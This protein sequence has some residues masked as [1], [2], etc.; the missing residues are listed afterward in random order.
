VRRWRRRGLAALAAG[1][2]LLS[3]ALLLDRLFP[4]PLAKLAELSVS[5]LD[6]RGEVLRAFP[7]GDG[8]WR[9]PTEPGEI[10]PRYR[11]MLLAWE[12]RRFAG[13]PGVDPLAVLRALWQDAAAGRVVS[14]A[15]TLTMQTARLL[16]PRPRRLGAKL[17][18]MARALQ[19]ERRL[20]K[21]GV[22]AAY[23]TLAPFGGNI[24]GVRAAARAYLGKEP[25]RLTDAEAALLVALPQAPE[26][27]RPDRFPE[28]ARQARDRVL[29]RMAELGVLSPAAVREAMQAPVP[30]RRLPA[31]M[32][33]PHL[34][35]RLRAAGPGRV[36]LRSLID[37]G[38]QRRLEAIAAAVQAGLEPGATVALLVVE[39]AGRAVRAY[40]GSAAYLDADSY[41][42]NDMVRAVR[43]PGS[44]LKPFIYGLGFDKLVVHPDTI[45]LDAPT[46]FGDYRPQNFDH[47]YRG[48]VTAREALQLSLNVPAVA[49]LDR[50]G[51]GLLMQA[52]REAGVTLRLPPGDDAPGLPIALGGAGLSLESL[53]RLYAALA[54]GGRSA[55]L[56]LTPDAPDGPAAR[57]V[58]PVAAWYLARILEQAPPPPNAI[59]PQ[60][61]GRAHPIA[62]KTGTSYGFRDAWAV[63]YDSRY[64]VGVWVGRPDG[65]FAADRLGRVTAAPLLFQVFAELPG[66]D[67]SAA[68]TAA[69]AS[70]P[71]GVIDPARDGLPAGLQR[72]RREP[73]LAVAALAERGAPAIA[74]PVDGATVELRRA[75]G[76]PLPLPLS[77]SGGTLPLTWLVNGAPLDSQPWRR[78][79]QWQPDGPGEARIT[80]LDGAGR[81]ASVAVWLQ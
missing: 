68:V 48:E 58:S 12:D 15:S 56:R 67:E 17:L 42:Q 35:E 52:L 8:A 63:G 47:Q 4:P 24:E 36:E 23:L 19:L 20:G 59:A 10:D 66:P 39:T 74:F 62:F 5:L 61:R 14:G 73:L 77:A 28:R 22:L 3:A 34:A 79:A 2:A 72:F 45:M 65:T 27:L 33:A 53:V 51:P 76:R 50:L 18:E 38:L 9:L 32:S 37:G 29:A 80:V 40:V 41:G 21:D 31:A 75:G 69:L 71:S 46:R 7:A 30:Q 57:L 78:Q 13:H 70:P 55:P 60:H 26:Q 1:L 6:E 25:D 64:T 49:L 44:T 54:D 16:E 81:S 43:S 11:R